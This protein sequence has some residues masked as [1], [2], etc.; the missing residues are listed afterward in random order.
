MP[1]FLTPCKA[2]KSLKDASIPAALPRYLTPKILGVYFPIVKRRS[3]RREPCLVTQTAVVTKIR[4]PGICEVKIRRR[5]ACAQDCRDC[6][7][8]A[9]PNAVI[10]VLA[11]NAAGAVPGDKVLVES[12]TKGTLSLAA[13]VY[14]IPLVL[15][16][17]G[18]II[19]PAAGGAGLLIGLGI[20][21]AA[22]RILQKKGGLAVEI[23]AVLPDDWEGFSL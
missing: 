23:T 9:A 18:W 12:S 20:C 21:L 22:N 16:F 10:E 2:G 5:S 3:N 15:F 1:V 11:R 4:A 13:I 19:H 7:G 14:L 6:A 17:I 8:C